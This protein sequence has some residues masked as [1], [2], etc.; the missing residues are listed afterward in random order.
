MHDIFRIIDFFGHAVNKDLLP[1][2]HTAFQELADLIGI[3]H[4][5]ISIAV[6]DALFQK[7]ADLIGIGHRDIGIAVVNAFAEESAQGS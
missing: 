5:D 2:P 4:R 7:T 1:E 3:R 6:F